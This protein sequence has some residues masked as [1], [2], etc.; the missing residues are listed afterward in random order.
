MGHLLPDRSN[1]VIGGIGLYIPLA[2]AKKDKNSL[3]SY[4]GL[5][6]DENRKKLANI[7]QIPTNW[8][9]YCSL[10]DSHCIAGDDVA[11]HTPNSE[12]E[13]NSYFI[14]GLYKGHFRID[15]DINNCTIH[16]HNCTGHVVAPTC[17]WTNYIEAQLYWNNITLTSQG[18]LLP[19][20]G[21]SYGHM[22]Q[23]YHAANET[24]SDVLFYWWS[25]DLLMESYHDTDYE[26]YRV[27]LPQTTKQ[28]LNY[29]RNSNIDKC[30]DNLA[31]RLGDNSIGSCDYAS[32]TLTQVMSRGF[33]T[34]TQAGPISIQS[35]AYEFMKNLRLPSFPIRSILQ[36]W[37]DLGNV[38]SVNRVSDPK[39][40]GVC[41]WVYDNID[42]FLDYVP[43][44]YPRTLNIVR[45]EGLAVAGVTLGIIT[46][47][48]ATVSFGLLVKWRKHHEMRY[49]QIY[50]LFMATLGTSCMDLYHL[51]IMLLYLFS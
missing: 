47:I 25:P 7:F 42:H 21:Y 10:H 50:T 51:Y 40:E 5:Q 39:R 33:L 22:I 49:S 9:T 20:K 23:I 18:P 2:T 4:F 35:P 27:A 15:D 14:K 37:D 30:S 24:K 45:H 43:K 3:V 29:R 16:P 44:G 32:E 28:C 38:E 17:E 11:D 48:A 31:D 36:D 8:K 19:N 12:E 41:Q 1:G 34:A 13:E 26:F 46:L 6:G